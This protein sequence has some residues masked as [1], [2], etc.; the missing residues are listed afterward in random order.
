LG[1]ILP[2][3]DNHYTAQQEANFVGVQETPRELAGLS[4][5]L[6]LRDSDRCNRHRE[7]RLNP[8]AWSHG[9]VESYGYTELTRTQS[10]PPFHSASSTYPAIPEIVVTFPDLEHHDQSVNAINHSTYN[11]QTDYGNDSISYPNPID[12]RGNEYLDVSMEGLV[13]GPSSSFI[14]TRGSAPN[15][16][17]ASAP[18]ASN[19]YGGI[20]PFSFRMN[21]PERLDGLS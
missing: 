21:I 16:L 11:Q 7:L 6:R 3:T 20:G 5:D 1:S 12:G 9:G 14:E 18:I 19:G 8:P 15:N 2:G 4:E 10:A 13:T 17:H